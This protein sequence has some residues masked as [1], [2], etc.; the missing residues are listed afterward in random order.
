ME[1]ISDPEN[2]ENIIQYMNSIKT[3]KEM[4]DYIQQIYPRW[5][6]MALDGYCEDYPHLTSN[7]DTICSKMGIK[8]QKI[9]LVTDLVFDDNHR[10]T[11]AFAEH[12]TRNGYIVRRSSEFIACYVCMKAIPSLEIW[13]NFKSNKLPCPSAWSI[14]CAKCKWSTDSSG[15]DSKK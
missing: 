13:K 1:N 9:I 14:K 5:L 7:W 3:T 12:M 15:S 4:Y 10:V 6:V 11:M 8:P 2:C